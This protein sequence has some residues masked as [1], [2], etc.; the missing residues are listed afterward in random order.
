MKKIISIA[1]ILILVFGYSPPAKAEIV[2]IAGEAAV[3]MEENTHEVLFEKNS[4]A[5]MYPASTTKIMTALIALEY[6][7]PEDI[8]E[9]GQEIEWIPK[10]SSKAGLFVGQE[11][12]LS[13]L[14]YGLML[15]S[16][17]DAANTIAVHIGKKFEMDPNLSLE[18]A[19]KVFIDLMNQRAKEIGADNTHFTNPHGYHDKDHYTTPMDLA[20]ITREAMKY[21]LFKKIVGANSYFYTYQDSN[22]DAQ[23]GMWDNYNEL[24]L[25]NSKHY[26]PYATG[27]KSGRTSKAGRC[28]VSSAK[29]DG[30]SLVA[31]VLKSNEEDIWEDSAQLLSYGFEQ[32]KHIT[33]PKG[34]VAEKVRV[35]NAHPKDPNEVHLILGQDLQFNIRRMD[36]AKI[37]KKVYLEET[38]IELREAE[39]FIKAPI[40]KGEVIGR[41]VYFLGE[42]ILGESQLMAEHGIRRKSLIQSYWWVII[43][44][45]L[46]VGLLFRRRKSRSL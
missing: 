45:V 3:L 39:S 33:I 22:G 26:Y 31:V 13:D 38:D 19:F 36:E 4:N 42:D 17:N 24:I 8:I 35:K 2:N 43:L 29:K 37:V 46:F 15:P 7:D 27:V 21:D 20:R 32:Y 12:K 11:I 6:G 1:L 40:Q 18:D 44:A 28:L 5:R 34:E 16:G 10:D 14:L 9:V 23:E 25:E 30:L 41:V